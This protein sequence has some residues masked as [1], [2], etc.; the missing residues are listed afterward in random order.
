MAVV[1]SE[2]ALVPELDLVGHDAEAEPLWRVRNVADAKTQRF[3]GHGLLQLE[4]TR[5]RLGLARG[6]GADLAETRARGEVG[7]GFGRE[8]VDDAS[9]DADLALAFAQW[10]QGAARGLAARSRPLGLV[11]W[12]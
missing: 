4:A 6:P 8:D 11:A 12:V 7:I 3:A 1:V 10:K 2:G 5:S 9:L